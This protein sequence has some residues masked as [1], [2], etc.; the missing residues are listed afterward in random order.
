MR[1]M[2]IVSGVPCILILLLPGLVPAR[3]D[4]PLDWENP[5]V[6]GRNREAPHCSYIPYPDI[7]SVPEEVGID[8]AVVTIPAAAAVPAAEAC[9][10][11]GVPYVV[12]V[13]GGFGE[14]GPEGRALEERLLLTM[15]A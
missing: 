10:R 11:R 12:V 5:A 6:F 3:A 4:E 2:K 8:L 7:E 15:R 14:S 1:S 9:G 13:A